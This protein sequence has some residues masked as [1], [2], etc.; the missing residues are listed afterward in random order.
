MAKSCY[1]G[2][3]TDKLT[4]DHVIPKFL[5]PEPRPS[6][7]I[8]EDACEPCNNGFSKDDELFAVYLS[9]ALGGKEAAKWVWK[10]KAVKAFSRGAA[11]WQLSL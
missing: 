6:N 10:N 7:L 9:K 11:L 1:L 5:F 8:T 4:A 3:A 2:G